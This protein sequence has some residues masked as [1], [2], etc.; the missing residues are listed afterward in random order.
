[1]LRVPSGARRYLR[2]G[3]SVET[4]FRE[5]DARDARYVVLRWFEDLPQVAKGEDID[6]LVA[7][8]SLPILEDL[9]RKSPAFRTTQKLDVY[10]VS[11][12]VGT[13]F[14]AMPYLSRTLA[15]RVVKD[16]VV[17]KDL[18]RVP[19]PV[20]HFD[21]M[22]FHAVYHKGWAS[23]LPEVTGEQPVIAAPEHNYVAALSALARTSRITA[24]ISLRGLDDYL[25]AKGLRPASDTLERF[26]EG[27]P[28]L[29]GE[30]DRIRPDIGDLTG[31]IV[32]VVRDKAEDF[33]EEIVATLDREG[34]EILKVFPLNKR[35]RD[36][37]T[38]A[39]RGGN[40]G[41]GP[42]RESGGKPSSMIVAY[43][44]ALR[45]STALVNP[46]AAH[47]KR[48]ARELVAG[49][50]GSHDAFNPLHSTDNGWQ[51]LEYLRDLRSDKLVAEIESK[52]AKLMDSVRPP[53]P[54][55]RQLGG[56]SRRARVDVVDHPVHGPSVFKVFRPGAQAFWKNEVA[57]RAVIG[58]SPL[59]PPLLESGDN[60]ILM[61]IYEDTGAHVIRRLPGTTEHQLRFA[62]ARVLRTF[63]ETMRSRG[64]YLLDLTTHNLVTDPTDGLKL[65]D[66]E[67]FQPYPGAVPD[68]D[69]DCSV[70]G[71][72][73][74]FGN[75]TMAPVLATRRNW[76]N[77]V[78]RSLFLSAI[79]GVSVNGLTSDSAGRRARAGLV[80]LF[81]LPVFVAGT[82]AIRAM[83]TRW[84][85]RANAV[86]RL[87][88]K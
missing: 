86:R 42:F 51:S 16:A 6:I 41:R 68:L 49:R 2:P 10:T 31:L 48:M 77:A 40:W 35:E 50:V 57:A 25:R 21:S 80:Q 43:D 58:D 24:E 17:L 74:E 63:V 72:P 19:A 53:W 60:W 12:L 84:Y 33:R 46:K 15:E 79:I 67:F 82:L 54:V 64:H 52:V 88:R 4:F 69:S 44:L 73:G 76:Y 5:L 45:D 22:A 23:G 37:A 47:A 39:I 62:Q 9:T 26:Q 18:Y 8:D 32:Y 3:L 11:G 59:V 27:N 65:L 13:N 87:I 34:F 81:W 55:L 14:R 85:S 36:L 70:V 7:D 78:T 61:R 75:P 71:L 83:G 66:F 20:D 1:M 38:A 56:H 28:W 30:L 29:A